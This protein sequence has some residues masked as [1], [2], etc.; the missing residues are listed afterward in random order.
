M[1]WEIDFA[2]AI[3]L[4]VGLNELLPQGTDVI[5]I[6]EKIGLR[7]RV[8]QSVAVCLHG[9]LEGLETVVLGEV[10]HEGTQGVGLRGRVCEN[11]LQIGQAKTERRGQ[12][13]GS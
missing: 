5:A 1:C 12:A 2:R 7:L 13:D 9:E 11:L 8:G 4:N 10:G 6:I 3:R